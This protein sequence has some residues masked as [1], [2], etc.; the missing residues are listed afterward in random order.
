MK[1]LLL[2][3][4]AV[5]FLGEAI[6]AEGEWL[7]DFSKATEKAKAE[8][9]TLLVYFTGSD[10]CPPCKVLHKNVFDSTEFVDYAKRSLVLVEVDFPADKKQSED[11]K[12]ANAALSKKFNIEIFP[13]TIVLDSSGKELNRNS[14]YGGERP[15]EFIA[16]IESL[17][18]Q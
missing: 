4:T 6:G 1:K 2:V 13:T 7:T 18:K 8:K 3:L 11:L 10:W 17:K 12:K 16:K 15:N 14:G 9:K 5:A